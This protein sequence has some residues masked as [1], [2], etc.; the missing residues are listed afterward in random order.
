MKLLARL[1][2]T[3]Q[4]NQQRREAYKERDRLVTRVNELVAEASELRRDIRW[5]ARQD[6]LAHPVSA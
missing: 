3:E 5:Q 6:R 1:G 2:D 4:L